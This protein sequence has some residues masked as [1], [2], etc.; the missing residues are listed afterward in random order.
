MFSQEANVVDLVCVIRP[1]I[2]MKH[3][4]RLS[5]TVD[6]VRRKV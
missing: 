6:I 4:S 1:G 2:V 3:W 5:R